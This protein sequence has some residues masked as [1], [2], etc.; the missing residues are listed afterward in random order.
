[1]AKLKRSRKASADSNVKA[2]RIL[3]ELIG[4]EPAD[5]PPAKK[6]RA[7]VALGRKG[8]KRGGPARAKVLTPEERSEIAKKAAAARW[9]EKPS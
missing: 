7:A 8:G 6:D 9:G 2:S 3:A 4:E 1:M 5:K